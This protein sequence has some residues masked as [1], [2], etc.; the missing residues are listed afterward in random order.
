[1]EGIF[2]VSAP[3]PIPN[4]AFMHAVRKA[5]NVRF[6]MDT[7]PWLLQIGAV[8]IG[9]ETELILKSRWVIPK[10]LTNAG[11]QFNIPTVHAALS[12]CL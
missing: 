5:A 12:A 3:N 1:M 7:P 2:N 9:T 4:Y 8:F 6:G 10:R 11:Y